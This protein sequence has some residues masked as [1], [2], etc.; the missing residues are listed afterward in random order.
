MKNRRVERRW[1]SRT[2]AFRRATAGCLLAIG[3]VA[4]LGGLMFALRSHLSVATAALVLVVP[5]IAGVAVG[6]FVAG[7]VAT[8]AGFLVYDFVFIPP[9][10]TMSVGAA[11]NWTALGVYVVVMVVVAKIVSRMNSARAQA[12]RSASEVRRMLY[13]S[14][15]LVRE[16]TLS[17]LLETV[18]TTAVTAFGCETAALV[19]VVDGRLRVVASQGEPLSTDELH[20]LTTTSGGPVHLVGTGVPGS[21]RTVALS[22]A[23]GEVGLLALRGGA[24]SGRE[25]ELLRTFANLLAL[26]LERAQF[27]EQAVHAQLL[28]EVDRIRRSLVGAV[29]HDLRT[30]LAAIKVAASTLLDPEAIVDAEGTEELLGLIDLQA[31]RLDRL[32]SNLL[33]MTRIQSGALVLRKERLALVELY[34]EAVAMLG[35][36]VPVGRVVWRAIH[37]LPLVEVDGVLIRQALVNLIDNAVRYSP[38]ETQVVVSAALVDTHIT[39]TVADCGA[40]I[41]PSERDAVFEMFSLREAGGRG[42]LGLAIARAFVEAHGER[43][44]VEDGRGHGSRFAF[45]LP[46]VNE[47][48]PSSLVCS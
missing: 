12:Q 47:E 37:D 7:V 5:V 19:M 15:R 30:P 45:T 31:D 10:Y 11:Q 4:S 39:V 13:L 42:G 23:S 3:L 17:E 14:Q 26:A 33:D 21:V 32:V 16:A 6:G 9:Y 25:E 38:P 40:G 28:E 2:E 24:G 8:V 1:S 41:A 48:A 36:S 44:W 35:P 27:R 22:T 46:V 18:V 43:I 29:S 20:Q 34:R